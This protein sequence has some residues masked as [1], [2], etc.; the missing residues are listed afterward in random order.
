MF[1]HSRN[2]TV[3]T[4]SNLRDI[5]AGSNESNVFRCDESPEL[6]TAQKQV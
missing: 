6:G 3:K 4:A 5:A 1:V 2:G